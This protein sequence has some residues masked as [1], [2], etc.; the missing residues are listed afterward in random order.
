M[1][2]EDEIVGGTKVKWKGVFDLSLLYNKMKDWLVVEGYS[3]PTESSYTEK[4]KPEGKQVEFVWSSF[5]EEEEY[6]NYK[7]GI[8]VRVIELQDIETVHGGKKMKLQK[9]TIE[10]SIKSSLCHDVKDKWKQNP[11]WGKFYEKYFMRE[12]VEK[13]EIELYDKTLDFVDM[14]KDF[15]SL[16]AF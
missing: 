6:F 4:V 3:E 2:K 7:I 10:I 8:S 12:N 5:K 13:N 11:S 15:L 14:I 1:L 16:Y 9:G